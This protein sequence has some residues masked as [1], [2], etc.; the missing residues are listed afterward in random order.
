MARGRVPIGATDAECCAN[1]ARPCNTL[2]E[3]RQ[4]EITSRASVVSL[5]RACE[6]DE[7][8]PV[9]YAERGI[10]VVANAPS[11]AR[12]AYFHGGAG[13]ASE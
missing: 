9:S 2:A 10:R 7:D 3:K 4:R 1:P 11:M 12:V 5:E 8:A 13:M 6:L